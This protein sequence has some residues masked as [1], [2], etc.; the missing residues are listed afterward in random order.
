M[1]PNDTSQWLI[2]S[3]T[4]HA[5]TYSR[6][7]G[8]K[9]PQATLGHSLGPYITHQDRSICAMY[10]LL[11]FIEQAVEQISNEYPDALI[12][13]GGDVNQLPENELLVR[14]GLDPL[15]RQPTRGNSCLDKIFASIPCYTRIQVVA[16]TVKSDHKAVVATCDAVSCPSLTK[17]RY[18]KCRISPSRNADL[19]N[20]LLTH[21][22]ELA[23]DNINVQTDFDNFCRVSIKLLDWYYPEKNINPFLPKFFC[24]F[25]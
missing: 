8:W 16:S 18:Y 2:Q 13:M 19:L 20:H 21:G 5:T 14:T 17:P 3:S 23:D 7:Y 24:N 25:S 22:L 1:C 9:S 15:V 4:H 12:I 10:D 6:L 11:D